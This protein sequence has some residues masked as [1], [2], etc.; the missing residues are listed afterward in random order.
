MWQIL[1]AV[2]LTMIH[3]VC[4]CLLENHTVI[5]LCV[6]VCVLSRIWLFL[7]PWTVTC[8]APLSTN[9][10]R[11]EC[12][13][14]LPFPTPGD[15]P[16]VGSSRDQTGVSCIGR[17]IFYH[18]ATWEIL[19]C[20]HCG[21]SL[22]YLWIVEILNFKPLYSIVTSLYFQAG[23]LENELNSRWVSIS[24]GSKSEDSSGVKDYSKITKMQT[25]KKSFA[26]YKVGYLFC[27]CGSGAL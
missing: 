8:Q 7:I 27:L 1:D 12:W 9:F 6:C 23:R 22:W 15:L 2:L 13:N 19:L 16:G 14:G 10:S 5:S 25:T 4:F 20:H 11:Q 3:K 18:C 26:V 17:W 21:I 24:E